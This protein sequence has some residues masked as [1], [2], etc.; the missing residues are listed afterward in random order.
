MSVTNYCCDDSAAVL[1]T[2]VVYNPGCILGHIW[3][4]TLNTQR[5]RVTFIGCGHTELV[6]YNLESR[7]LSTYYH[8]SLFPSLNSYSYCSGCVVWWG[9][10]G[11]SKCVSFSQCYSVS[12]GP[13][14][15][16][17]LKIQGK[18]VKS[19]DGRPVLS[20]IKYLVCINK[21]KSFIHS[22]IIWSFTQTFSFSALL[23][24]EQKAQ[25]PVHVHHVILW[26]IFWSHINTLYSTALIV[27]TYLSSCMDVQVCRSHNLL[28]I[29][30]TFFL[31]FPLSVGLTHRCDYY[32]PKSLSSPFQ[33]SS[34]YPDSSSP[35][36][37]FEC[38]C[39]IKAGGSMAKTRG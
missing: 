28:C 20:T 27:S 39:K 21:P 7:S 37:L 13:E 26:I 30:S 34:S 10:V 16:V 29:E 9:C 1:L 24:L 15:S 23:P 8:F 32:H 25:E 17:E 35:C 22:R 11:L 2:R 31:F 4:G 6:S 5:W 33:R 36:L 38:L 14:D 19:E 3:H 12:N 18:A